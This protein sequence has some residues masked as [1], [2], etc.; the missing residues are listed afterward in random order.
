LLSPPPPPYC[1]CRGRREAVSS[2]T[3]EW[4]RSKAE[5][6]PKKATRCGRTH[7]R[8]FGV[9]LGSARA[10]RI[11][12]LSFVSLKDGYVGL[13]FRRPIYVLRV[14]LLLLSFR[15]LLYSLVPAWRQ[16]TI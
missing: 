4:A 16:T 8:G 9:Q 12:P 14:I 7:R 6:T 5:R 13:S 3:R 15:L 1:R 11:Y 10:T 2:P